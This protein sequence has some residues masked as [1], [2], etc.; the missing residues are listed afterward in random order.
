MLLAISRPLAR[1]GA[2]QGTALHARWCRAGLG[3]P[4]LGCSRQE[5]HYTAATAQTAAASSSPDNGSGPSRAYPREPRVGV[6][7]VVFRTPPVLG[8]PEPEV[9]LVRRAK[10]PDKGRWCL[11]GGSLELG[12]TLADCAAREVKEEAG[13]NLLG[14]TDGSSSAS[15][16]PAPWDLLK[17]GPIPFAAVDVIRKEPGGGIK[18][19]YAVIEVAAVCSDPAAAPVP[20]DDADGAIWV[21]LSKMRGMPDLT[22]RCDE[23]AEEA[24]RRF[25]VL[26]AGQ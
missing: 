18:F 3:W 24:H 16:G 5:Y 9:L 25:A 2:G 21:P 11:P 4:G 10:E 8:G 26:A 6:G 12:E 1:S 22:V 7:V 13:L 14:A 20:G 19:H 23:M 17:N 15:S